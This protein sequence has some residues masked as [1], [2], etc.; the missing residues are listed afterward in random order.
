[1]ESNNEIL[2]ILQSI[3][4]FLGEAFALA[5]MANCGVNARLRT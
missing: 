2:L 3:F 1:M 4:I 5:R